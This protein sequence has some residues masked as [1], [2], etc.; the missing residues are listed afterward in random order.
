MVEYLQLGY[1][2]MAQQIW[3]ALP[4]LV[5]LVMMLV[6]IA[7]MNLMQGWLPAP[8]VA[9]IAVFFWA[10]HGPAFMP[11]WAVFLIGA[12]QD[13]SMDSPLGFWIILYLFAY[14]FTL[15]Q[16][17]FFRGRTGVGALFG[18]AIVSF[19]TAALAWLFGTVVF[20]RWLHPMDAFAQAGVSVLFY[21][22]LSRV[23]MFLRNALTTAPESL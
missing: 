20:E 4:M 23:F 13:F 12:V 3:R 2:W 16:R 21:P 19:L 15:S 1:V 9:L 22:L 10:L 8:D 6:S 14:G 5:T 18:F 11:P 17:I 7:P